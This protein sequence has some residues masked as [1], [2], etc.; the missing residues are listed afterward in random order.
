MI[1]L[2]IPEIIIFATVLAAYLA[3]AIV[4]VLQLRPVGEKFKRCLI[5]LIALAV[6]LEAVL[7]IFRAVEIKAIPLTG[8]FE[9]MIVLTMV[10]GLIYLFF[11]IAIKEVWFG[12]V[13]SLVIFVTV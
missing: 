2:P 6:S 12:T 3:A 8:L 13:M 9:S 10:F 7:L 5:P 4:G 11:A 1:E